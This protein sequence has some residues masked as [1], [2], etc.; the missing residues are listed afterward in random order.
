MSPIRVLCVDDHPVVL[1]GLVSIIGTQLDMAVVA[2]ASDGRAAIAR[3]RE[4]AP[5]VTVM[6]LLLPGLSGVEATEAIRREFP[7]AR[8]ILFTTYD[9]DAD[10]R[11][12]LR[13]GA[14]GYLLK[15]SLRG[16]ILEA[17][18]AVHRGGRFLSPGIGTKLDAALPPPDLTMREEEVLGLIIEGRN[19]REIAATLGTAEGTIRIHVSNVLAK[20]GVR[21]RTQAAVSAIRRGLVRSG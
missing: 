16:D 19:N 18:R 17:V 9:G 7:R 21:D 11:G 1:E 20:L 14:R 8:V 10:I 13:A 6:D 2:Q 3:F 5:D 12:A 4:H 15:E